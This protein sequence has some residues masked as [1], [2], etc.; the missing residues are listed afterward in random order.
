[1]NKTLPKVVK[2]HHEW[3]EREVALAFIHHYPHLGLNMLQIE[4]HLKHLRWKS[5][6]S[7][8]KYNICLE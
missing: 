5:R 4:Q 6:K 2:T 3:I 7:N 8:M 1:L